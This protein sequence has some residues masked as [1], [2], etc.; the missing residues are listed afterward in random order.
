M[1]DDGATATAELTGSVTDLK[2]G[3]GTRRIYATVSPVTGETK[4][5]DNVTPAPATLPVLYDSLVVE[6]YDPTLAPTNGSFYIQLF[7][8]NLTKIDYSDGVNNTGR[9]GLLWNSITY[10]N[11]GNGLEPGSVF[12]VLIRANN[13]TNPDREYAIRV[14]E[15]STPDFGGW[16][17]TQTSAADFE[18]DSVLVGGVPAPNN[19]PEI[20]FSGTTADKLVRTITAETVTTPGDIDWVKI[21]LP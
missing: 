14:A 18:Q 12:Y 11:G 9:Y 20:V 4:T 21:T 3:L 16:G 10:D 7:D 8:S 13:K 19:P 1:A 5:D 2:L 6:T 15:P 17:G